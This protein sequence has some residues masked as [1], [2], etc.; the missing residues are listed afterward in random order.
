LAKYCCSHDFLSNVCCLNSWRSQF[1][2]AT[3]L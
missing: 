3:A 1:K 2:R